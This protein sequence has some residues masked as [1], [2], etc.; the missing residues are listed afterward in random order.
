MEQTFDERSEAAMYGAGWHLCL[1]VLALV[2]DGQPVSRITGERAAEFGW[3]ELRDRYD[4]SWACQRRPRDRGVLI[5]S[6]SMTR[7][8]RPSGPT[9]RP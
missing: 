1:A 7:M 3:A 5:L 9:G 2:A 8:M 6:G 4:A